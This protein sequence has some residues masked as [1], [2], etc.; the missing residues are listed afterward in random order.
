MR[1][2][3]SVAVF[4]LGLAVLLGPAAF[5]AASQTKSAS[6][7]GRA[8]PSKSATLPTSAAPTPSIARPI[9]FADAALWKGINA[10]TLSERGDWFA[11]RLSPQEG[12]SSV[13][14]RQTNGA[15]EYKFSIGE[16]IG[17]GGVP[18]ADNGAALAISSD[19]KYAAF[20]LFPS[21]SEAA[22]LKKDKKPLQSR[23][24]IVNLATGDKIEV[25]K[26]Q[27]FAFSGENGTWIALQKYGPEAAGGRASGEGAGSANSAHDDR[28]KGSD[29][30]LRE[31]ATGQEINIGNVSEF[32]FDKP[33]NY[34]AWTT[35][36]QD[37]AGN[38]VSLRNIAEGTI[39]SIESDDTAV[40][41]H[42]TWTEDGD[43]LAVLKGVD[44]KAFDDKLYSVVGFKGFGRGEPQKIVF[45]PSG[46]AD[47]PAGMTVSPDRAPEWTKDLSALVFGIHKV[48][49]KEH[50]EGEKP[51]TPAAEP[52]PEDK[53]DLVVWNWQ[54]KR[55]QSEQQVE[56][57][58]DKTF[59]YLAVY[60]PDENKFIRLADDQVREVTPAREGK[61]AIGRA[62]APYEL[63]G[64]L[65]GRYYFDVYTFNLQ[66]GERKL[67][68]KK[69]RWVNESSP[70]GTQFAYYQDG[71]YFT[72]DM[73]T[74]QSTNITK[75]VP[76]SFID[77]ED[78][79]NIVKPPTPFF[80]WSK[81]GKYVFLS[82]N[83]DIWQIAADRSTAI[84]LT[85]NG[86]KEQIRYGQPAVLNADQHGY[87]LAKPLYV[88]VYGEWT[89]KEGIG[90]I[91]PGKPGLTRVM[92]DDA[93]YGPVLKARQADVFLYTRQ[94][95]KDP[96][97][98]Y[99]AG[100]A[101]ANGKKIT[102]L[103][104]ATGQDKFLWSAGTILV[105][106][107]SDKGD[108]LQGALHLPANYQKGKRYPT[109]VYLYEK[110]SQ[111]ANQYLRP[112]VPRTGFNPAV[113]TS[114]GY[115][116]FTPDITYK[117]NDPGMSA[118]WC[119]V[120][121]VKALIATGVADP[122]HIGIHGHSWGGYQTAFIIT[123]T[124]MFAAAVAGAPLT[125][126]ISMYAIV[127][128]NAGVVNG[129]I[130]ESSQGRFTT[131]PWENWSAYTRNSP[132][133]Q[134]ANVKTPLV[135]LSNDKDG[136]V[137]FTQGMEYY[138]TLRRLQKPVVLLE[139]PGENHGLARLPNQKDYAIRMKEF[140]DHFLMGKPAPDWYRNG[141]PLLDMED[142]LKA[143]QP[144]KTVTT[145]ATTTKQN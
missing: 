52:L 25:T 38:G 63:M 121:A 15:K 114:N 33:G 48:K 8:S 138:N 20:T 140:F 54:D 84:N 81:D 9:D 65:D 100:A 74:G 32:A 59:S 3:K 79:H 134:A 135:I 50:P 76:A 72:Y 11:Y 90:I 30:L 75:S 122:K 89:K 87:D 108:K 34:L 141:V 40:Y 105:D 78:D 83:W 22:Q 119:V 133:A 118:V 31:L 97:D 13:I 55:L 131:G 128:K 77:T 137:D 96:P 5:R 91:E 67:A 23:V 125:D 58:E 129:E 21:H 123:Q 39:R 61:Y 62:T 16:V 42:L 57:S 60:R 51:D 37:K 82:D 35:D 132:V 94:T 12:D 19:S 36:A 106:Y 103:A 101:I 49:K 88:E 142:Y 139:Y 46:F 2:Y 80:G 120:P 73:T 53:V 6:E 10:A 18:G 92:W 4:S 41:S 136:A 27:R 45:R 145:V 102:D 116:V 93:V 126:M 24:G 70:T 143:R 64:N 7:S 28:P 14:I 111:T 56:E 29:L 104:A 71:D 66:T 124:N 26:V 117:L 144:A 112:V 47:F 127:Y 85:M 69:A 44:D 17:G 68:L 130:F 99:V 98:Y 95:Y 113:Y 109:I 115:A 110:L 86:R 107:K 43:G 1:R